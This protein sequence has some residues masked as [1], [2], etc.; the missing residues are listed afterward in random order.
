MKQYLFIVIVFLTSIFSLQAQHC[1]WDGSKI[2]VV[3]VRDGVSGEKINGL[4]IMLAD[5]T[6]KPYTSSWNFENNKRLSFYQGTDTLQFGQN[7][8][9]PSETCSYINGPFSFGLGDYMLIVYHNNYPDFNKDGSDLLLIRD[10]DGDKNAG[11]FENT[12]ITFNK[13]S[14]VHLCT[15]M[16]IW[17]DAH[18]L[19]TIK[20]KVKLKPTGK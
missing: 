2:I 10:V 7:L 1:I 16:P 6:H 3:E 8:K 20:V 19:D 9:G 18:Y 14:I 17:H 5:S 11:H 4:Q 15:G 12:A 13:S